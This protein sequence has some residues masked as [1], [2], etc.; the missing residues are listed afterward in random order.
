MATGL[1]EPLIDLDINPAFDYSIDETIIYGLEDD[2]HHF[3]ISLNRES[4]LDV[5]STIWP[6]TLSEYLCDTLDILNDRDAQE[7]HRPNCVR[8]RVHY[9]FWHKELPPWSHMI[10]DDE[11]HIHLGEGT[12]MSVGF[13]KHRTD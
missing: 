2:D 11:I 3:F 4:R 10:T 8:V 13:E 6:W 7:D 1:Y 9:T 5:L 12:Y